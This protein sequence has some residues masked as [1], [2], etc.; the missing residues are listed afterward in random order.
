MFQAYK[1]LPPPLTVKDFET[2]I[3]SFARY[4]AFEPFIHPKAYYKI[5]VT[6]DVV[7]GPQV[8]VR[9]TYTRS[10]GSRENIYDGCQ[11]L[12]ERKQPIFIPG[13]WEMQEANASMK[14]FLTPF[15]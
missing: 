7:P 2:W 15:S 9:Q 10:W 11:R 6:K 3:S 8:R 14:L 4:L 5:E 13:P 12:K 1:I